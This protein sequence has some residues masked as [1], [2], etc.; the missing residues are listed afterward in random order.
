M[1]RWCSRSLSGVWWSSGWRQACAWALLVARCRGAG[2]L[3]EGGTLEV[4]LAVEQE[5]GQ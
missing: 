1:G 4:M 2:M 3:E 5:G